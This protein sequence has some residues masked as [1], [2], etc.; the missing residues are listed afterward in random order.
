MNNASLSGDPAEP[1]D[2]PAAEYSFDYSQA[3][4][5]R[6]APPIPEGD[7]VAHPRPDPLAAPAARRRA[8]RDSYALLAR[9]TLAEPAAALLRY[10]GDLPGF[11]DVLPAD[12]ATPGGLDALA[13]AYQDLFGASVYP[14]E[15]L[16]CDPDLLLNTAATERVVRFYA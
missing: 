7:R 15:A 5:N 9:L 10:L 13:A 11:G 4:P 8:R 12:A 6:F 2:A 14:Y 16:F 3:Q 1:D